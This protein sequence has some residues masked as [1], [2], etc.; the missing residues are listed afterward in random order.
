MAIKPF[1]NLNVSDGDLNRVQKNVDEFTRQ[2]IKK[3]IV[4]SN[5]IPSVTLQPS[6]DNVINHQ[7]NRKLRGYNIVLRNA[8]SNIWDLQ[9]TNTLT[10]KTLILRTN[11]AVTVAL[12][13]F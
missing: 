5:Y 11:A 4:D 8:E 7:L 1:K 6:Q 10:T 2:L 9:L 13:V 3:H 12:L